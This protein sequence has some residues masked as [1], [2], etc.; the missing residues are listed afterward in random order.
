LTPIDPVLD[1]VVA[2]ALDAPTPDST[3]TEAARLRIVDT[4]GCAVGALGCP[5]AAAAARRARAVTGTPGA[6]LFGG[7]AAMSTME[8]AVFAN[9][10]LVR[11]LD[12]ND[13]FTSRVGAGCHPS[14]VAPAVL[15]AVEATGGNGI[16]VVSGLLVAYEVLGRLTDC[17]S[18]RELGWDHGI[19]VAVAVAAGAGRQLGL[20]REQL[21]HAIALAVVP[22]VP[23]RVTRTGELSMW[24]A[25]ATAESAR[26]AVAA[27]LLAREGLSGPDRP[28]AGRHG[29]A[30]QVLGPIA[31]EFSASP[32][33]GFVLSRTTIKRWPAEYHA[34]ALIELALRLRPEVGDD[35]VTRVR[36]RTYAVCCDAIG[37]GAE[38]RAPRTRETADH[39]LPF[40]LAAAMIDGDVT[41]ASFAADHLADRRLA[42]LME[43]V[44][45]VE[46]PAFTAAFPQHERSELEVTTA[47]GRTFDGTADEP[48]GHPA[49][50]LSADAVEAKFRAS[51]SGRLA[52][53]DADGLWQTWWA[54]PEAGSVDAAL[55]TVSGVGSDA[56]PDSG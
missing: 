38:V 6:T 15:A 25:C 55:A 48:P 1:A 47:S 27:C 3:V 46:E 10:V 8:A 30:D 20:T 42:A 50:P 31:P 54:L 43:R 12:R 39:S 21:R 40:L 44:E 45:V 23:L 9:T 29:V 17:V 41:D 16:D 49:R 32:A 7:P 4:V 28:F 52:D 51:C 18:T 11:Y 5:P 13:A 22:H 14:D 36:V 34:Q 2:F 24:K 53:P 33:D 19:F 26:G 35:P 56:N 37:R